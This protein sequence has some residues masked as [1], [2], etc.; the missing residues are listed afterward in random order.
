MNVENTRYDKLNV[1]HAER[2][3][4]QRS[5]DFETVLARALWKNHPFVALG[6]PGESFGAGRVSAD[7][8]AWRQ[9][10]RLL[11]ENAKAI[12]V[13][14]AARPGIKWELECA[15]ASAALQKCIFIMPPHTWNLR[16]SFASDL[17]EQ[18]KP[19]L[20]SMIGFE[21]PN[22]R[23]EGLLFRMAEDGK[24]AQTVPLDVQNLEHSIRDIERHPSIL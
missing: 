19:D 9:D 2:I 22:Y 20:L 13:I 18:A 3:T 1:T 10:I 16:N 12:F 17:W 5:F 23:S 7:N 6:R 14:P 15:R 21:L 24:V 11:M 4:E 8:E